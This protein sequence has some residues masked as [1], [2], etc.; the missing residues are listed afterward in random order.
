MLDLL[1][2]LLLRDAWAAPLAGW[3]VGWQNELVSIINDLH[4]AV[5]DPHCFVHNELLTRTIRI[6]TFVHSAHQCIA[7]S[8]SSSSDN[9]RSTALTAVG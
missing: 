2:D 1:G 4:N 9:G 5:V 7:P 8:S 6:I 3:L